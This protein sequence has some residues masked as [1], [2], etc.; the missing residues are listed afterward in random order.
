MGFL[1]KDISMP[2]KNSTQT[3]WQCF[4]L[5]L[6]D[7]KKNYDGKRRVLSIIAEDFTYEELQK[8]LGVSIQHKF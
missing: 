2:L 7:N 1:V 3:F 4:N 6:E 5:A 8:N